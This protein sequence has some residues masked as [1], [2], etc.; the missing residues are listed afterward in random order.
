MTDTRWRLLVCLSDV[1]SARILTGRLM[2]EGINPRVDPDAHVMGAAAHIRFIVGY[3]GM[4]RRDRL[5]VRGI[6]DDD[7]G[8]GSFRGGDACCRIFK[9]QTPVSC[10]IQQSGGA[11]KTIG[12]RFTTSHILGADQHTWGRKPCGGETPERQL[13]RRRRQEG[14]AAGR[15]SLQKCRGAFDGYDSFDV[16]DL[17]LLDDLSFLLDV[18]AVDFQFSDRVACRDSVNV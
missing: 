6:D 10:Y 8:S 1:P 3:H 4:A 7:S 13:A 17:R 14:P 16:L 15:E 18:H 2:A 12:S 5:R 9:N 11:E